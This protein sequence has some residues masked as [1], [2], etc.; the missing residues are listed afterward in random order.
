M[1]LCLLLCF[2]FITFKLYPPSDPNGTGSP[3]YSQPVAVNGDGT[4]NTPAPGYI[5]PIA[6]GSEGVY[7]WVASYGGDG[8]NS[9]EFGV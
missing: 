2:L 5:P 3:V 6:L 7:H 8:K 4:Y 1:S 9:G